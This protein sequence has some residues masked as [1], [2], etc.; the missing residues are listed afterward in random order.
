MQEIDDKKVMGDGTVQSVELNVDKSKY[1]PAEVRDAA[2][3]AAFAAPLTVAQTAAKLII[4]AQQKKKKKY[5]LTTTGALGATMHA[6]FPGL[7]NS[8]VKDEMKKI[9]DVKSK[10]KDKEKEK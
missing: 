2:Q 4:D 9:S 10:D 5:Q 1:M 6:L 8:A 3:I 7:I